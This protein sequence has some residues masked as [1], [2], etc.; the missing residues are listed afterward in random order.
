MEALRP[1]LVLV[2]VLC[3]AGS[4]Q[5][6]P[7]GVKERY[8]HFLEQHVD[9]NMNA[10]KCT[11]VMGRLRL[12]EPDG[13]TCKAVN[14]FIQADKDQVKEIC[15]SG[16]TVGNLVQSGQPFPL[17]KCTFNGGKP[18]YPH[19]EYRGVQVTRYIRIACD[20]GWPVHYGGDIILV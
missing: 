15:T 12:T 4:V 20:Q 16:T 2:L 18:Y 5:G 7:P 9:A 17:I 6:Q 14:T 1:G 8:V 10:H 13:K 11:S 19:C 3:A